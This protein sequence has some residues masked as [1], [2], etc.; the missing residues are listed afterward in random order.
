MRLL[1]EL[2]AGAFAFVM[3]TGIVSV[4]AAEQSLPLLSEALLALACLAWIVLTA[5]VA[6]RAFQ[7]P[8]ARPR[9]QSFALVAATAVIGG[10]FMQA[11]KATLALALWSA[12]LAAWLLLLVQRPDAGRARG[13]SLLVV[14]ATESLAFLAALLAP[15]WGPSLLDFA[16]AAWALGLALYPF[17]IAALALELRR[18]RRFEPTL[19]IVMGA[20]AIATLAG[21]ELVLAA[22]E[23]ETLHELR[24]WL[25]DANLATWAVASALVVPLLLADVRARSRWRYELG[26]WSFVFPLGMYAVA[27]RTLAQANALSPLDRIGS[28]FFVIA[29]A[30]WALVLFGLSRRTFGAG[31][32]ST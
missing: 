10:R 27:S 4:A 18:R 5:V 19:W 15:R 28:V 24:V 23:L 7:A 3:A 30:A 13:S 14:V 9:L 8:R 32:Q 26:R 20:L 1:R 16:L 2:D 11:G 25:R 31:N 17:V 29:L 21:S 22:R 6:R 12:A